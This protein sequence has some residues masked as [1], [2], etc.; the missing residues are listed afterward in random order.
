MASVADG[1]EER[2][3][4]DSALPIYETYL[5]W[6][7][8][9]QLPTGDESKWTKRKITSQVTRK[10]MI[11]A[12]LSIMHEI[13]TDPRYAYSDMILQLS[14][15]CIRDF[16]NSLEQIFRESKLSLLQFMTGGVVRPTI[17]HAGLKIASKAKVDSLPTHGVNHPSCTAKLIEGLGKLTSLLQSQS[18]DGRHLKSTERGIF[19]LDMSANGNATERAVQLVVEAAEAGFLKI[20]NKSE[21]KLEF[22]VHTSL[23]P[24][25]GFSY[26]GAYY[27]VTIGSVELAMLADS[28]DD[29]AITKLVHD[30]F[31]R[32]DGRRGTDLF[33]DFGHA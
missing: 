22:R 17:Q 12:Y 24:A 32:M 28:E 6:R 4:D 15:S 14:D 13:K 29:K 9:K 5:E 23:A 26:R 2:K 18:K 21:L 25:F 19:E 8:N 11:A 16:L 1:T 10:A 27:P 30:L 31:E 20:I 3:G 33:G 7:T